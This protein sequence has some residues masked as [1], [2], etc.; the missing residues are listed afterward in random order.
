MGEIYIYKKTKELKV[1]TLST[2]IKVGKSCEF[3]SELR[4]YTNSFYFNKQRRKR[5]EGCKKKRMLLFD[6]FINLRLAERRINHI[7]VELKIQEKV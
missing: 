7:Q 3:H 1:W 2:L 5:L 6:R 4:K